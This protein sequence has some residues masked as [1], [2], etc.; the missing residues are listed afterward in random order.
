MSQ[1]HYISS[2]HD[3][4]VGPDQSRVS[5]SMRRHWVL[6]LVLTLL[7]VV[8]GLLLTTVQPTTYQAESQVFLSSQAAFDPTG[9]RDYVSDPSR[10]VEEQ[11]AVMMSTPVLKAAIEGG[12]DASSVAQLR[13]F[14]EV[15]PAKDSNIV[16]VRASSVSKKDAVVMVDQIVLAYRGHIAASVA[17]TLAKIEGVLQP[18]RLE[19]AQRE[20]ALFGDGV[21]LAEPAAAKQ[22]SSL[23]RNA[24]LL[25]LVG[26]MC[27]IGVSL[28][29][30]R[31]ILAPHPGVVP[32]PAPTASHSGGQHP[33]GDPHPAG[34]THRPVAQSPVET[35]RTGAPQPVAAPE[36]AAARRGGPRLRQ[37]FA[38]PAHVARQRGDELSPEAS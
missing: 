26:L 28:L 22:T 27:S 12:A 37:S 34:G 13:E 9:R 15:V 35:S 6:V 36:P 14:V 19:F 29:R 16:T 25:G 24:V 21:S 5:A 1:P 2:T 38:S 3:R 33:A 31:R 11:A 32:Y 18:D 7:G 8:G 23:V 10:F 4:R 20:A 30:D 17:A